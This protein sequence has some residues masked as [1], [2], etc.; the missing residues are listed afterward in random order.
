L[1]DIGKGKNMYTKMLI[2][3]DGSKTAEQVLPFAQI[4]AATLKLPVELLDVVDISAMSA[5]IASDKARY[6]GT[7]IA[8]AEQVNREYLSDITG[9]LSGF[10][11]TC[12]VVRGKPADAIIERA[13]AEKGTLIAM[14]THG[15]SGLNRWML[16]SVA[17]K[18]LRGSS[19]PLFLVRA[20]E[21]EATDGAATIKSIVVPLDGSELAESVLSTVTAVAKT[22]DLEVVLIRAYELAASAYYGSEDYLPNYEEMRR[23]V[24]AEVESYLAEKADT[25]KAAGCPR[26]SWVAL[27]GPSAVQIADYSHKH[28]GAVVVMCTHGRSGM[29]RWVLGSV[30]E[31]VVRHSSDPVLVLHAA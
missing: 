19:N 24:K 18:V 31:K 30:T 11:V 8:K 2:P 29:S 10:K 20:H 16:G 26:V 23:H 7:L 5:H 25:L 1:K 14:A 13:A 22:L 9:G 21:E 3:L 28:P 12:T 15:R 4:L 17:E 6:L 27:E